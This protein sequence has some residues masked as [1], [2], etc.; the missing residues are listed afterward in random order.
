MEQNDPAR[1]R[2]VI[3]AEIINPDNTQRGTESDNDFRRR[4]GNANGYSGIWV[5][6]VI[7]RDG[8]LAPAITLGI[9]IV[10]LGQYG[11]LAAIGFAVFYAICSAISTV[12]A[13]RRLMSGR[14]IYNIWGL[15][16]AGWLVS[17]LITV[18]LAG[19]LQQ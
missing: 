4:Y 2:R 1:T 12:Y 16:C 13:A 17:F 3:E 8:C 11:L 5:G 9:F 18:W 19:G 7:N 15:R 6:P 10:C 14:P